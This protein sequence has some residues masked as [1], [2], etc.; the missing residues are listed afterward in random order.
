[1]IS[2]LYDFRCFSHYTQFS[3]QMVS[4]EKDDSK[5]IKSGTPKK[6]SARDRS[7]WI[8]KT[9]FRTVK[10]FY[11]NVICKNKHIFA[12]TKGDEIEIFTKIDEICKSRFVG[13]FPAEVIEET[14]SLWIIMELRAN[15]NI[16]VTLN[17][18]FDIK[19]MVASLSWR[20]I[21][22]KYIGQYPVRRVY[23]RYYQTLTR[24]SNRRLIGLMRLK[25]FKVVFN[26]F[27]KS[28]DFEDML[29]NDSTL[30]Q[31]TDS[32]RYQAQRMLNEMKNLKTR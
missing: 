28:G 19:L 30:N 25:P 29:I 27:L 16:K 31:S 22:K 26:E 7:D 18:Y 5:S 14:P 3:L 12:K 8:N 9:L 17:E 13:T 2:Y 23:E 10:K 1:M 6:R 4:L 11:N 24:Y 20:R 32:Y 21:I 15:R